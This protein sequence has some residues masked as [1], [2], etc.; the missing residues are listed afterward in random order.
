VE[1]FQPIGG[2][3]HTCF[4]AFPGAL[5]CVRTLRWRGLRWPCFGFAAPNFPGVP[6]DVAGRHTRKRNK[7]ELY[8]STTIHWN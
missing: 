7:T 3:Y 6:S 2:F 8:Q 4:R 1:D 5:A